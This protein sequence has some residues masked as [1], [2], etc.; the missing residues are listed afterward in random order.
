MRALDGWQMGLIYEAAMCF[1]IEGLRRAYRE[2]KKSPANFDD[3]DLL[4]LGYSRPEIA[5]IKGGG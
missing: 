2:R 5:E 3:G 1:P 4:E